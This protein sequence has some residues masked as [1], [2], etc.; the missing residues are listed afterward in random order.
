[1][2]RLFA[3]LLPA[4]LCAAILCLPAFAAEPETPGGRPAPVRVWGSV[5]WQDGALYLRNDNDQDPYQEVVVHLS[6]ATAVVDA[7]SGMPL[8]PEAIADGDT[9]YAWVGPAVTLSLPPQSTAQVVVAGIPADFAAPQYYEVG[10]AEP[11][12]TLGIPEHSGV[13]LT[14]LDGTVL[15]VMDDAGIVPYLT[16]NVVTLR[17]LVPGA[18]ILV[19]TDAAGQVS[20]VAVFPYAYRGYAALN[21]C[22]QLYVDGYSVSAQAREIQGQTYLP[23]RAVAEA[24]GCEVSWDAGQGAVVRE[25]GG[26]SGSGALVFSARPDTHTA[27]TP[28]GERLLSGT[29]LIDSGVTYLPAADLAD[30]LDL[31]W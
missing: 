23:V 25:Q 13:A 12:V 2:K 6:D 5:T 1:M 16:K 26:A 3:M 11:F 20:R 15:R 14:A 9:V 30:L 24:A 28:D 21:G 8:A 7:V 27:I 17:D 18:R 22:G 29:C 10:A 31:F 4:A 19:W